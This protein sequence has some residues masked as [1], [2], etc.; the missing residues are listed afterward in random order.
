MCVRVCVRV[1]VRVCM[2][3]SVCVH[4]D[5]QDLCQFSYQENHKV[6]ACACVFVC[7]HTCVCGCVYMHAF[8]S[9]ERGSVSSHT[10][11][12]TTRCVRVRACV[13]VCAF[14]RTGKN[15]FSYQA[16]I[17]GDRQCVLQPQ[18]VCV[19][20]RVCTSAPTIGCVR[21]RVLVPCLHGVT[22]QG[23][24]AHVCVPNLVCGAYVRVCLQ[25]RVGCVWVRC[26]DIFDAHHQQPSLVRTVPWK[27]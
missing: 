4:A 3:V 23:I 1:R 26:S 17:S 20:A 24:R 21:V 15:Q 18:G 19:C 16:V 22:E 7:V 13:C 14:T 5:S 11:R 6:R 2:G 8:C 27:N 25:R 12:T 9:G 10:K